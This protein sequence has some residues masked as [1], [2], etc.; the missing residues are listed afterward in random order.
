MIL[1]ID[2]KEFEKANYIIIKNYSDCCWIR[3]FKERAEAYLE[4][5]I[6][7]DINSIKNSLPTN[8]KFIQKQLDSTDI[9]IINV[10]KV[11]TCDKAE[12]RILFKDGNDFYLYKRNIEAYEIAMSDIHFKDVFLK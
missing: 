3:F 4:I 2:E 8:F 1:D 10:S 11:D 7:N 6:D 9:E 12:G 5:R